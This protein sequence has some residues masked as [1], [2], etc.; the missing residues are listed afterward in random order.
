MRGTVA[1]RLR[2]EA[3]EVSKPSI[4]EVL[5]HRF[6]R[7]VKGRRLLSREAKTYYYMGYRRVYQDLKKV[8]QGMVRDG[9]YTED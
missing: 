3:K 9:C 8:Y 2:A 4:I 6:Y 1:K 7:T 5:I